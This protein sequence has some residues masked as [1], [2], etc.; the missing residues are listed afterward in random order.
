V[1]CVFLIRTHRQEGRNG[2]EGPDHG[3][4]TGKKKEKGEKPARS[5]EILLPLKSSRAR[6]QLGKN[7]A[8]EK[9]ENP[10][11]EAE[12]LLKG[13]EGHHRQQTMAFLQCGGALL[14]Q[15]GCRNSTRRGGEGNLGREGTARAR[16]AQMFRL[17]QRRCKVHPEAEVS[18]TDSNDPQKKTSLPFVNFTP[19]QTEGKKIFSEGEQTYVQKRMLLKGDS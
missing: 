18:R 12:K 6:R 11:I 9:N 15:E 19:G 13:E 14:N 4:R 16:P 17:V 10:A 1:V 8:R 7:S 2:K 3:S 5:S